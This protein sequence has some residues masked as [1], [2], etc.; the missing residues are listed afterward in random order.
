MF[1]RR[2]SMDLKPDSRKLFTECLE[3]EVLPLLRGHAGFQ[4]EMAFVAANGTKAFAIS[5]WDSRESADAYT[6]ETY[7]QGDDDPREGA[8]RGPT[9]P[10]VRGRQLDLSQ[11]RRRGL[12]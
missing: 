6:R 4:D 10:L 9:G 11:H 2:V 7:P 8:R 1:A 3:Q 5:F 12:V